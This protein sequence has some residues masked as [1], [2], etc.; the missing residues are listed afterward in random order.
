MYVEILIKKLLVLLIP[1]IIGYYC[2]KIN[3]FHE[4]ANIAFSKL[5]TEVSMPCLIFFSI[6]AQENVGSKYDSLIILA[7]AFVSLGAFIIVAIFSDKLYG[8][9]KDEIGIIKF[10]TVFN[11]CSFMGLPILVAVLNKVGVF[12][13]AIFNIANSLLVFTIGL[14]YIGLSA[15]NMARFSFKMLINSGNIATIIALLLYYLDIKP[16]SII[17]ETTNMLG[18]M[19]TPLSM[20]VLGVSLSEMNIKEI[21]TEYKL[22]IFAIVKML[23]M[24]TL[25]LFGLKFAGLNNHNLLLGISLISAMPGASIT[26]TL[27]N[28][29]D[30][31]P[32]LAS[33]YMFISTILSLITIP[34]F[35]FIA[36]KLI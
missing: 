34:A 8:A 36:D 20:I 15:K 29:Y 24:P 27:A 22:Y 11:N 25:L 3:L 17:S 28:Q 12:Y 9:N 19:T 10:I 21:I 26:V 7:L 33:K 30:C 18:S 4:R 5:M 6:A 1:I 31:N 32:H 2:R 13:I 35:V 16:F 23:I 14:Y